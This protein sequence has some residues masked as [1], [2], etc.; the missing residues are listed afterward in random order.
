[1]TVTCPITISS[2]APDPNFIAM[3]GRPN[4]VCGAECHVSGPPGAVAQCRCPM[5]HQFFAL[6]PTETSRDA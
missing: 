5:G 1:M 4:M 6:I 2:P 3:G